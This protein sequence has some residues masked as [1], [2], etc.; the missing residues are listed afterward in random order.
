MDDLHHSKSVAGCNFY[1]PFIP[2]P[3][4]F[5]IYG[6][7][8]DVIIYDF[9]I[10]DIFNDIL[11]SLK[12]MIL[13]LQKTI[14]VIVNNDRKQFYI[15]FQNILTKYIYGLPI[16]CGYWRFPALEV[17]YRSASAFDCDLHR[18][19]QE[20]HYIRELISISVEFMPSKV[21]KK[22]YRI[23]HK[24]MQTNQLR[25]KYEMFCLKNLPEND[26]NDDNVYDDPTTHIQDMYIEDDLYIDDSIY[27]DQENIQY[28]NQYQFDNI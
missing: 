28:D 7:N 5:L 16:V 1:V 25:R 10:S 24:L 11:T 15:D 26:I 21:T 19:T 3:G 12:N 22:L 27:D 14:S 8:K 17:W 23:Y 18:N 13:H 2:S 4:S 9:T 20:G 6:T